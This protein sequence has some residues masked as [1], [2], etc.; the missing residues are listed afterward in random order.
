M[1]KIEMQT[2]QAPNRE[3]FALVTTLL[4]VL[5]LSVLAVAVA[6]MATS[7]KK[8]SFAEGVHVRSVYSADAG[9]EAGINFL[10]L[11]NSPPMITNF[12]D[13]EVNRVGET[14]VMN[15]QTYEYEA[16]YDGKSPRPGWGVDYMDYDY[17]I[18]SVGR[19]SAK[20][21]SQV[22]LVA[23]RLFKEGY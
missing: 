19:A 11:S 14:A 23:S 22:D 15:S 1:N 13:R 4:I 12:V 7:E 8:I 10:R 20:G 3:G 17:T 2:P 5:V 18:A 6:W 9:G 16:F 21:Q